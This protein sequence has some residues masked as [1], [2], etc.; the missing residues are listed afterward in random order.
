MTNEQLSGFTT[1]I[2]QDKTNPQNCGAVTGQLL[3]LITPAM[4]N[5]LSWLNTRSRPEEWED[6]TTRLFGETTYFES[7]T[8]TPDTFAG[9]FTHLFPGFGTFVVT[10]D[11]K[12][13]HAFA[14]G[15]FLD[16]TLVILDPQIRKGYFNIRNYFQEVRPNDT[17]IAVIRTERTHPKSYYDDFS[18]YLSENVV[19]RCDINTTPYMMDEDP[20]TSADVEM[21]LGGRKRRKTKRRLLA[22]RTLRRVNRR[23]RIL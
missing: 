6:H 10:Y 18:R 5:H 23:R 11:D 2:T 17:F 20:P 4:A 13:G 9:L 12:T 8:F 1:P 16:G 3:K 15:R 14:V 19:G 7:K 21:K 22:K